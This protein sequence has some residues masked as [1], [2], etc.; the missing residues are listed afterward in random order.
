MLAASGRIAFGPVGP[1]LEQGL[2]LGWEQGLDWAVSWGLQEEQQ[3]EQQ[4]WAVVAGTASSGGLQQLELEMGMEL[5]QELA[6]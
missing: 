2:G 6:F 4:P 3:K 1:Q 5:V